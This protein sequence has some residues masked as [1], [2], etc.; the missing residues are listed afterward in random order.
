MQ[1]YWLKNAYTLEQ[2]DAAMLAVAEFVSACVRRVLMGG[3]G[4]SCAA[5]TS[6]SMA[7]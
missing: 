4:E 7:C 6:L 2:L 3:G 1:E 5:H